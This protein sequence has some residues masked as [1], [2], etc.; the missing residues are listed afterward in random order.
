MSLLSASPSPSASAL[1]SFDDEVEVDDKKIIKEQQLEITR[2][3]EL[4]ILQSSTC[5][6]SSSISILSI[7]SI[8][9]IPTIIPTSI[10]TP[11]PSTK[12]A[13]Q[14]KRCPCSTTKE[15]VQCGNMTSPAGN[16]ETCSTHIGKTPMTNASTT[17]GKATCG[18]VGGRNK[19][20]GHCNNSSKNGECCYLHIKK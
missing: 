15:G 8:P 13:Q 16:Y 6:S 19:N 1:P 7:P 10:P 18:D 11:I 17:T 12:L 2:L 5:S 20:G 14:R 4:L 3:K 9:S